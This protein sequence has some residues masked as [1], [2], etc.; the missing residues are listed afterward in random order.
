MKPLNY[1]LQ[2]FGFENTHDYVKSAFGFMLTKK[3]FFWSS[4]V[5]AVASFSED[6]L[7]LPIAVFSA[8]VGLNILEFI[9]G[10][11]ASKRQGKAVES[12]KMGRMF[13]KIG[14]YITIIWMLHS[15]SN[16]LQFPPIFGIEIKPFGILYWGFLAG[17]IYQLYKSLMENAEA[18]GWKEA[19]GAFKFTKKNLNGFFEDEKNGNSN[20]TT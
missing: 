13:F 16:G 11:K 9:T 8:F 7:G 10:I 2:G 18:L 6:F 20:T 4:I 19:G 1:Y 17:I 12:R 5:G 14:T 3:A 15:F